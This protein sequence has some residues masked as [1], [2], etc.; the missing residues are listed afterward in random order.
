M[1][2]NAIHIKIGDFSRLGRVSVRMLRC[3][4]AQIRDASG[5]WR[6][7]ATIAIGSARI[8]ELMAMRTATMPQGEWPFRR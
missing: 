8:R 4:G 7:R 3:S 1:R 5:G 6:R 2:E